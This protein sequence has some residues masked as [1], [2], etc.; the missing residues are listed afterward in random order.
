MVRALVL[1]GVLLATGVSA[2][3][4]VV[5]QSASGDSG[6]CKDHA[7]F[8]AQNLEKCSYFSGKD[9]AAES[10]SF[11]SFGKEQL[12]CNCPVACGK[13]DGCR[14]STCIKECKVD[15][16]YE[17][18][19]IG[20]YNEIKESDLV[21]ACTPSTKL[22]NFKT[23]NHGFQC[24]SSFCCP[25]MK[26]CLTDADTQITKGDVSHPVL[27]AS[28]V[29]AA[30]NICQ[31]TSVMPVTGTGPQANTPEYSADWSTCEESGGRPFA[32]GA[33]GNGVDGGFDKTMAA[34]ACQQ[35]YLLDF[36][37]NR[38][39]DCSADS[40]FTSKCTRFGG[41]SPAAS[42]SGDDSTT[43]APAA[44]SPAKDSDSSASML[45]VNGFAITALAVLSAFGF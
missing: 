16:S 20:G 22:A 5:F 18:E 10:A 38:W 31:V 8:V 33:A 25:N 11:T 9:C 1:G 27:K 35:P 37:D 13:T 44:A 32:A 12:L 26:V 43:A 30:A 45:S 42:P 21:N 19:M 2:A 36:Y 28:F 15:T 40:K 34:C 41:G 3:E 23:C 14:A 24:A 17:T 39:V 6:D 4:K 7:D 29:K